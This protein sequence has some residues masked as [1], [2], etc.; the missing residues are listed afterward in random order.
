MICML[1]LATRYMPCRLHTQ[2]MLPR[3]PN[4]PT[5]AVLLLYS[6]ALTVASALIS[7][8]MRSISPLNALAVCGRLSLSLFSR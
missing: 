3:R 1:C 2:N 4:L 6:L 7:S 8:Y 5:N